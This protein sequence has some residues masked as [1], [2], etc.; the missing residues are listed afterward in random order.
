MLGVI[1]IGGKLIRRS[2]KD[3]AAFNGEGFGRLEP[4]LESLIGQFLTCAIKEAFPNFCRAERHDRLPY[5]V[6]V[7]KSNQHEENS[8]T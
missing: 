5:A 7:E 6:Y 4:G 8:F 2:Y 1:P 3:G